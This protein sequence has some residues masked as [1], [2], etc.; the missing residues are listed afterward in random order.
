MDKLTVVCRNRT[1]SHVSFNNLGRILTLLV[2]LAAAVAASATPVLSR[3][4][5]GINTY[6]AA[7]TDACS[8]Y[9]TSNTSSTVQVALTSNNPAVTVPTMVTV[10]SGTTSAGFKMTVASVTTTQTATITAQAGGG[11]T[12]FFM[13]LLSE[14]GIPALSL[15]ATSLSFG[16]VSVGTAV[17][18]SITATSTGTAAVTINSDSISGTGVSGSG[19][20]L[21]A[22]L[23]PGEATVLTVQ[24]NPTTASS[25]TGLLTIASNA[26]TATVSLSGSGKTLAPTL[27]SVNCSNNTVTGAQAD[28]CTVSL[29]SITSSTIQVALTSN[30][31]AVI[32]PTM[33]TVGSG[34]SSTGFNATV[35]GVTTSQT[36]TITAQAGGVTT[37]FFM[38]L[39]PATGTPALSLSATSLSFGNVSVGTA[40]TKSITATSTG[41]AAVSINS[42]SITGTGFSVSGGSFPATLNP[43]QAAVVT[44]QFDPTTANST[45]GQLT[46][47]SNA[48]TATV[49]LS[50]TGTTVLPNV[51]ALS[52]SSTSITGSFADTCTVRLSGSAPTSGLSVSLASSS[53][54]V[55][56]PGS[57]TVPATSTSATF[58][59]NAASVSTAQTATVTAA[60]G[61]TS[62]H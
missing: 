32:V 21:P 16:N 59:A 55:T 38:T 54:A 13:T 52:C 58:T 8:V 46:L 34:A 7:G 53:S 49:S 14:T 36:A 51:S 30:N 40:V 4:S 41:T 31:P 9:L 10:G 12:Y 18:K 35:A 57:V 5:C 20:T 29:T 28:S 39:W 1:F 62:Q 43:G 17:T 11:T 2:L 3:V 48:P 60:T 44:V 33:V 56:V 27:R 47:A 22:T 15:N 37:Y 50:G 23:N 19:G 6:S 25:A 45:T 61:S 26:P 24:F 42:D